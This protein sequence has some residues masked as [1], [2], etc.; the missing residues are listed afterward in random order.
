MIG[1]GIAGL[2]CAAMLAEEGVQV[3]LVSPFPSERAQSVMAAGGINAVLTSCAAGDSVEC[4]IEDTLR[5]GSFL[6]GVQAV[7]G[8]C[9]EAGGRPPAS[10]GNA[11]ACRASAAAAPW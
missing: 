2:S 9:R 1:S 8:L 3:L 10:A 11:P 7:T 4:H 5:G 6:G